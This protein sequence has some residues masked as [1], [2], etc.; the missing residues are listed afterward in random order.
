MV[1]VHAEGEQTSV[2]WGGVLNI[3]GSTLL[4]KMNY[5]NE[6]DDS[7]RRFT[8]F[9]PRGRAQMSAC[10]LFPPSHPEA[11]AGFI[12]LQ[13]D[14]AH[15]MSGSNTIGVTTVLL[16]TGM[17]PMQEPET[18]VVLETPAGMIRVTAFCRH[19]K[20]ERVVLD[21]VPSFVEQLSVP[22]NVDGIGE[23]DVDIAFGGC[24]YG[25]VDVRR[26]GSKLNR[27]AARSLVE[28]GSAIHSALRSQVQVQHP[29]M[30]GVNFISYV[31][32]FDRDEHNP[33]ILRGCAVLPPGRVDRSP[34]GT[35]H[36]ARLACMFERGEAVVGDTF[37]ARSIIDSEFKMEVAACTEVG[38]RRAVLPRIG[39]RAWIYGYHQIGLDPDDP[40]P[41]GFTLSDTWGGEVE[42]R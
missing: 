41:L 30:P 14:R 6:V 1:Q 22:V 20:C 11:H 36:S 13:A 21:G 27:Q 38:S 7:I 26:I 31:M 15:A 16:E 3:P 42:E 18:T 4:E 17:V 5:I 8:V 25:L 40:F 35:G 24:Y 34:C 29:N 32:F 2:V 28:A 10:L 19:G 12:V 37:L 33:G 39:G 23:V 9:E